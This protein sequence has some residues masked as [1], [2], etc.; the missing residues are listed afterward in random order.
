MK[1]KKMSEA[2]TML[3]PEDQMKLLFPDRPWELEP[4]RAEWYDA[5]T[6]YKCRIERQKSSGT[7]CGYVGVFKGHT[8]YGAMYQGYPHV[9]VHGGLTFSDTDKNG[10]H[11]FGFDTA[12]ARDFCPKIVESMLKYAPDSDTKSRWMQGA[13]GMFGDEDVYRTWEYVEN[14]VRELVRAL[15]ALQ[16]TEY[17]HG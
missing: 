3:A 2:L 13:N 6:G 17:R 12:H 10:V 11:W 14:E 9:E 5:R 1:E 7:L 15:W 16:E 8:A 4:D